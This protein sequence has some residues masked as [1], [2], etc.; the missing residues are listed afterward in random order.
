[1][2][3]WKYAFSLNQEAVKA[4]TPP[5]TVRLVEPAV[6]AIIIPEDGT[7]TQP[8]IE[9][10]S[11]YPLPTPDPADPLNWAPWRKL[12]CISSVSLYAFVSNF[13]SA[14]VAPALPVWNLEFPEDQRKIEELMQ[15]V[16]YNVLLL[17]FGNV[18]LVPVAN[19]FGRRA[20]VLTSTL[21]LFI[22]T[23]VGATTS[24][25]VGIL[26]V[27]CFQGFG[28][29]A[30]ETVVPA[31]VGEMYF[32]HERGRWMAFYTAALASGSVVGGI[33]GGYIAMR[34][35][36]FQIFRVGAVLAGFTFLCTVL[37]VPETI[38][39][40]GAHCLPIQRNLP[41]PSRYWPRTAAPYLSL[42]TLPSMRMTLPSRF[43]YTGELDPTYTWYQASS[44][45]DLSSTAMTPTRLSKHVRSSRATGLTNFTYNSYT[46]ADSLKVGMYRGRIKY[47]FMKPWYTLRLPATWIA[48]LQ[49]GGLVGGVAVISTI[50]PQL[51]IMPPYNWGENTGLLFIGALIGIILGATA[52]ALLADRRLKRFA[53]KQDHG[54]AEPE[55]R[56]PIMLPALA[57][58]TGGLLV[59]GFC[60]QYPG[61]Y[62]WVGLQFAYGMVAFALTQVPSLWFSYLIDAYNQLASDCF[63]MICILRGTVP[64]IWLLFVV[65]W[66]L[67]DGYLIPFGG[68]TVIMGVFS[69]FIVPMLWAGKRM[70]IATA[71]YVVGNQ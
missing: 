23:A 2:P 66:I 37:F 29:S 16:A 60:A 8:N 63:V 68:F 27:R 55:T 15:F 57:L 39:E 59:F 56:L 12:A 58:G 36:W 67:R 1:M 25:F 61:E 34:L 70:R 22:A 42:V 48:S 13:I 26:I 11:K 24:N 17:G 21:I 46:F 31:V 62:Q 45:D 14:C 71:R 10:F 5:G 18:L 19:I 69:L 65:Q 7:T 35:G 3:G 4:A 54:Y 47:Q 51:L 28:S 41:R 20:I 64:F 9:R 32:V 43:R 6:P 50:G 40:R 53:K 38:Y 49:Y 33:S 44:S 30:S 52:T